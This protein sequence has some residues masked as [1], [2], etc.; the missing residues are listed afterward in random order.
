MKSVIK[1]VIIGVFVVAAVGADA[2]FSG[3]GWAALISL[4]VVANI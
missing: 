1:G 4:N 2:I 3:L